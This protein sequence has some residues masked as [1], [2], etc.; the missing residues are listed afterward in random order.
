MGEDLT[1]EY[2]NGRWWRRECPAGVRSGQRE[3]GSQG[4]VDGSQVAGPGETFELYAVGCVMEPL[5]INLSV[6]SCP[7]HDSVNP[8]GP[9]LM[10]LTSSL[11][12]GKAD[13]FSSGFQFLIF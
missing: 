12:L 2:I 9:S 7:F 1:A 13:F 5:P 3:D 8:R 6:K 11:S 4:R 10:S